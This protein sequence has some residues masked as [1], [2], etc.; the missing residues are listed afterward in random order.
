MA[1]TFLIRTF[2]CQMNRHDAEALAGLLERAGLAP[3][4]DEARADVILFETCSVRAHA[5]ERVY[6]LLG[7]LKPLK[8]RRPE[9]VIG[10]IGCMAEKDRGEILRRAPHVDFT[11]GPGRL[12]EVPALVAGLLASAPTRRPPPYPDR[13]ILSGHRPD[14]ELPSALAD[15][16]QHPWSAY[17]A[18][19]RGCSCRCAYCVVPSVRGDLVS[20]P[21]QEILDEA[22]AL[23]DSGAGEIVLL[24]QNVDAYGADLGP[25]AGGRR[26]DLAGLVRE[27]GR[28]E[29][30]GL[31]R[32]SF[33]TS[34]PRDISEELLRAMAETPVVAP[35][36]HMPAQSGSDRILKAMRR[37]YTAGRYREIAAMAR[38]LVPGIEIASDFIVGFPG[39][40]DDDYLATERLVDELDFQQTFV[41]KYSPRPGTF[42]AGTLAD[43]VPEEVKK[44]RNNR[45]LAVQKGISLRS[46]RALIGSVLEVLVEGESPR[47]ARRLAGRTRTGRIAVF[48][49][50][51]RIRPGDYVRV[52]I[53]SATA[54]TLIGELAG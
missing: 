41:F 8:R 47:D 45:L 22:G 54:L 13:S 24:G 44:E 48:P 26:A 34:H 20:R 52:R 7:R 49:R 18:I 31:R 51:E 17:I 21:Q 11:A 4:E 27:I 16:S 43:D 2:G 53:A 14:L 9:T 35:Y 30:R 39:E 38:R 37:G 3:T 15:R 10:V 32:L 29:S 28:L 6:S 42:A 12:D 25:E 19:S 50:D 5:E 23:V 33:V 36:L 46:N 1:K 40:T